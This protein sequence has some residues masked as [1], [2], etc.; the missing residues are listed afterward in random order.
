MPDEDEL[1]TWLRRQSP[2]GLG[3]IGDD[4]AVLPEATPWAV[5]TDTQIAGVHFVPE[6]DPAILAR[7]LL[8]VNLSDLAAMGAEPAYGFLVLAVPPG[9]DHP[10][11]FESFLKA[12]R[13]HGVELAGGDLAT[14]PTATV[15]L[16]LLG[17]RSSAEKDRWLTRNAA[18]PGDG[19]WV[20]GTLGESAVGAELVARGARLVGRGVELPRDLDLPAELV[21][22]AHRAVRRHLL[23]RPQLALGRRLARRGRVAAIDLSDGLARDLHRLCRESGVGAEIELDRLPLSAHFK[24]LGAELGV[25]WKKSALGG[26]EDYILLFTLPEGETPPARPAC[27]QIGRIIR[28]QEILIVEAEERS[29]LPALGWDHLTGND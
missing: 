6:L 5:T 29:T 23:P 20:G 17:R 4:A 28:K 19:L 12:A 10:R 3:L 7:R 1:L 22:P 14:S 9:F 25:D 16:T 21:H 18:R 26:G 8:A 13:R 27:R 11:F 24:R 2:G 15:V